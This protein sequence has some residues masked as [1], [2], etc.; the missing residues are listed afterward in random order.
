MVFIAVGTDEM[1]KKKNNITFE[2]PGKKSSLL[3]QSIL[4]TARYES[5]RDEFV[6]S[7]SPSPSP[8]PL[9]LTQPLL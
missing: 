8:P 7:L 5:G 3:L 1:W 6:T 9:S 2:S 4:Q